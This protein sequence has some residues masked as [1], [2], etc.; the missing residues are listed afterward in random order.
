MIKY[1][2]DIWSI[3]PNLGPYFTE[4]DTKTRTRIILF[5]VWRIIYQAT[6][7]GHILKF[8]W[9]ENYFMNI[10]RKRYKI[11][12]TSMDGW[13][14]CT[15]ITAVITMKHLQ[16]M[17]IL[18]YWILQFKNFHQ[19]QPIYVNLPIMLL[20][21]KLKMFGKENG[22]VKRCNLFRKGCS[23]M[24]LKATASGLASYWIQEEY[25][26]WACRKIGGRSELPN[27]CVGNIIRT[28]GNDQMWPIQ[29]RCEWKIARDTSIRPFT[30][31]HWKISRIFCR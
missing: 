20:F 11:H 8:G 10:L 1:H 4:Q 22:T 14:P 17:Q 24:R 13:I 9:M 27:I 6:V 28:E 12:P 29:W 19:T 25:L 3:F 30:S 23:Q 16:E 5:V 2:S 26:S 18:K 15:C 21:T 7:I 31:H